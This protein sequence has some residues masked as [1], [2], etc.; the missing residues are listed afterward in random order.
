MKHIYLIFILFALVGCVAQPEPTQPIPAIK[1]PAIEQPLPIIDISKEIQQT[2]YIKNIT[3]NN[4]TN[5]SAFLSFTTTGQATSKITLIENETYYNEYYGSKNT[6]HLIELFNLNPSKLYTAVIEV[7]GSTTD[8]SVTTFTTLNTY[9]PD[10]YYQSNGYYYYSY[11]PPYVPPPIVTTA[12]TSIIPI[13]V[14]N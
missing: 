11:T 1:A 8:R 6:N 12:W 7:Y 3:V 13:T 4:I 5:H 10:P 14:D 9:V 2:I